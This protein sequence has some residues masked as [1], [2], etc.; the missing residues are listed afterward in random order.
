MKIIEEKV[1]IKF[2]K[3]DYLIHIGY[4]ILDSLKYCLHL[5]DKK[6]VVIITD[7]LVYSLFYRLIRAS[8]SLKSDV[9]LYK[10]ILNNGEKYKSIKTVEIIFEFLLKNNIPRDAILVALGGGVVGDI[11]GFVSSCYKRGIK[12]IQIPTT[13]VSQVDSSVGGKNG[14]NFSTGKNVIGTFHN[15]IH[16]LIDTKFIE[17]LSK[18][19]FLSGISEVI[20]YGIILDRNF[21]FW[22]KKNFRKIL[23]IEKNT[24][25]KV[26]K[27]C[28]RL[29]IKVISNDFKETKKNRILLNLGHTFAHAIET[30]LQYNNYE[31]LHGEAV[32]IGIL[33]A[34]K[35]SELIGELGSTDMKN[36]L[37]LFKSMNLLTKFPRK[38]SINRFIYIMK[39]DKKNINGKLNLILPKKIGKAG[40]F[41][42]LNDSLVREAIH[43]FQID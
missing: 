21:F 7:S 33:L 12:F 27:K 15:P 13:L 39:Q 17:T 6:H 20:K 42:S 37:D 8:F 14:I 24:L 41:T 4:G 11:V 28:L 16:V 23:E 35:I 29:K 40:I 3:D 30:D 32:S 31:I 36:I 43:F 34:S 5:K 1:E 19:D 26:V 10:I 18:R 9:K 38:V 25:N 22:I 2:K